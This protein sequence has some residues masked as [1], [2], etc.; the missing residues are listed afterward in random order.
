M[1]PPG[2]ADNRQHDDTVDTAH[3]VRTEL[4][5]TKNGPGEGDLWSD[6]NVERVQRAFDK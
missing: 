3:P 4:V 6:S 1:T 5:V 2:A